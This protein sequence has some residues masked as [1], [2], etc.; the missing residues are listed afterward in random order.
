M[1]CTINNSY[2]SALEA[3]T[4]IINPSHINL[5]K[6]SYI[7][8]FKELLELENAGITDKDIRFY[9]TEKG[10]HYCQVWGC[11]CSYSIDDL[12]KNKE[13]KVEIEEYNVE[14]EEWK[15]DYINSRL[16]SF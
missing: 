11:N 12:I 1:E 3:S 9:I 13:Y 5:F 7:E 2:L 8:C 4:R 16:N 10:R 15:N 6:N 14:I